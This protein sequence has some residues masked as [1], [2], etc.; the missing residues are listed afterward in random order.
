MQGYHAQWKL[1]LTLTSC[2]QQGR[3][4][5]IWGLLNH[6]RVTHPAAQV[7]ASHMVAHAADGTHHAYAQALQPDRCAARV[8]HGN[9]S[10][11]EADPSYAHHVV[12]IGPQGSI[13]CSVPASASLRQEPLQKGGKGSQPCPY[14]QRE[15]I[16]VSLV[17]E[18]DLLTP[19]SRAVSPQRSQ[20]RHAAQAGTTPSAGDSSRP[21]VRM[22]AVGPGYSHAT[23]A[24]AAHSSRQSGQEA[25]QQQEPAGT[26]CCPEPAAASAAGRKLAL[27]QLRLSRRRQMPGTVTR[28]MVEDHMPA[29]SR[30]GPS[31][32]WS[33][34]R[35]PQNDSEALSLNDLGEQNWCLHWFQSV[36][37]RALS[38]LLQ[39]LQAAFYLGPC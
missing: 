39:Q 29:R 16:T 14:H 37:D 10:P 33:S 34:R 5:S 1:R 8:V 24:T 28:Q 12:S 38:A 11:A 4:A 6:L 26:T 9:A 19:P 20:R 13:R 30:Q 15:T 23:P 3:Q 18:A 36:L 31:K 32:Q 27:A 21:Y 25:Q 7:A 22:V 35:K 17:N 2:C